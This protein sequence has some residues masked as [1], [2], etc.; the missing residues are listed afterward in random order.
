M[1]S[2]EERIRERAYQIWEESG[3]PGGGHE[4]HWHQAELEVEEEP[5]LTLS[6]RGTPDVPETARPG[7]PPPIGVAEQPP[8][9]G[10]RTK[11]STR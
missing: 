9:R 5:A 2:K 4:E 7:A 10:T 3:R 11:E 8:K 1:R 6:P